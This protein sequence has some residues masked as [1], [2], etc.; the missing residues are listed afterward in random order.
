[1]RA[2]VSGES[3]ESRDRA[4][5]ECESANHIKQ[6]ARKK[7][8]HKVIDARTRKD[9]I[10]GLHLRSSPG[11]PVSQRV[12][13]SSQFPLLSKQH[14]LQQLKKE[15]MALELGHKLHDVLRLEEDMRLIERRLGRVA[16]GVRTPDPL[17]SRPV[18]SSFF[19][20]IGVTDS[21]EPPLLW[22]CDP[23]DE[24]ITREKKRSALIRKEIR[25]SRNLEA[26]RLESWQQQSSRSAEREQRLESC[27]RR[28]RIA[29]QR[30]QAT[31][32]PRLSREAGDAPR[33]S[34]RA[35]SAE[36]DVRSRGAATHA[37]CQQ[38]VESCDHLYESKRKLVQ[39]QLLLQ[40]QEARQRATQNRFLL[41]EIRRQLKD[42][43]A[44]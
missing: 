28:R 35:K 25:H 15:N 34:Q 26:K 8:S 30:E 10:Q 16:A 21:Q 31:L 43:T 13:Q 9:W 6:F 42:R 27:S 36:R 41:S 22:K 7:K 39:E 20:R 38:F 5:G 29:K 12:A 33:D 14:L 1:M 37:W 3:I 40:E 19:K 44:P 23:L 4:S 2:S 11:E 32:Q 24:A 17:V 18:I